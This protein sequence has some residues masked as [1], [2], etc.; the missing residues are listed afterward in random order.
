MDL[1]RRAFVAAAATSPFILG[2]GSAFA[3]LSR[4]P[5]LKVGVIGCGGRGTGAMFNA[6]SAGQQSGC[7]IEIVALAD[8]FADRT[9]R[10]NDALAEN[11]LK[12]VPANRVFTGFDAYKQACATDA[13]IVILATPPGFR[14][15][16]FKEATA[17]GKHVFCEK[18]VAVDA[19]GV[20]SFLES[21]A[22]S[23]AKKLKVVAGTQ[24]RHEQCYLEALARVDRGDIGRVITG[25][26]YWNMGSLWN[27]EPDPAK[28]DVENQVRNWL[29]H[30]WLSG[31][32][33]V[34]QH[35][36]QLDVMC[37]VMG[38]LPTA[39]RGVGGRQARTDQRLFGHIYDHFGLEYE[40]PGDRFVF[41]MC[42]QQDGTDGKVEENFR[43]TEG[44]VRLRSGF[45]EI[46]G[47]SPWRFEGKQPDPY[48]Q[49]HI[50]LQRAILSGESL[51]EAEQVANSTMCA[52]M[53]RMAAYTGKDLTWDQAM[54]SIEVLMPESV[55]FGSREVAPIAIPGQTKLMLPPPPEA[56]P[57]AAPA[58]APASGTPG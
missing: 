50:D 5:V 31:D 52:I 33:I 2:A 58:P 39:V 14:P 13:D 27:V 36:H 19:P 30:S 18:P 48:T 42:R 17:K 37:W 21:A 6:I 29:Y 57:A 4:G 43:G 7:T 51:N 44:S 23:R 8:L 20:R 54:S 56:A 28:T 25:R 47:L 1:N 22:E 9:Q 49:E 15:I 38:G 16:H 11:G 41:S 40:F 12:T 10:A 34:E 46:S 3:R 55:E 53:G 45:A 35:V 26:V 24:R 32:H